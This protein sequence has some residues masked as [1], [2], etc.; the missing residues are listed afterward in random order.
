MKNSTWTWLAV[1]E[2][3]VVILIV[4]FA[5]AGRP[6]GRENDRDTMSR[7]RMVQGAIEMFYEENNR[8][9]QWDDSGHLPTELAKCPRAMVHLQNLPEAMLVIS[10]DGLVVKDQWDNDI[11]YKCP[12]GVGGFPRLFSMGP[13]GKADTADDVYAD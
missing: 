2:L 5:V 6:G 9:P 7:L 10:S 12:G 1:G 3:V 11:V 8:W 4:V 13:D